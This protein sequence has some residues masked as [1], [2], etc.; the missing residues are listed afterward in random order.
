MR[1]DSY[2]PGGFFDE[3]FSAVGLPRSQ[4]RILVE[5]LRALPEGEL[6]LRQAA[7]EKALFDLGI[8]FNVYNSQAGAERIFPFDVLPR[9]IDATEWDVIER[10]LKQRIH[11][12]NLFL[13]DIYHDQRIVKDGVVPGELIRSATGY[14]KECRGLNPPWGVWCHITG[15][16]LVKDA[17]GRMFVLEDNLRCPSGVSYMIGNRQVMKRAF[18]Q[19]FGAINPRPVEEYPSR[20]LDMLQFLGPRGTGSGKGGAPVVALLTPGIHNSAYF[21]H[22]FLAQQMGVELVTGSDLVM[23]DGWVN[24]RTTRGFRRVDVLYRRIDD[25]FLDPRVFRPDSMLGVPGLM[26]AYRAGRVAIANAPGTGVAD[27]KVIYAYVPKIIE[28][29]LGEEAILPNV[30]TYLC[31][32]PDQQKYVLEHMDELVIKTANDSGGYGVLIGPQASK[33]TLAEW[34]AR[35]KDNPRNFIAQRTLSLSRSPVMIDGVCE[36]RHVDLRPFALYGRDIHVMPGGLT[37]VALKKGSLVVNSS[38]GGGSKDTWVLPAASASAA[39]MS[40]FVT[41]RAA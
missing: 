36:G 38:Q 8:T 37:R 40:S 4:A 23:R 39:A 11:A 20:L 3:M 31:W 16:D 28:Y 34:A 7:A 32:I 9:L 21:E 30:D 6:E 29:Y 24:M 1:L 15:S 14:R 18:P 5:N 41:A 35:I 2:D 27:D 26:E 22:S 19:I 17:D 25:D 13:N 33:A 12:L 10:G